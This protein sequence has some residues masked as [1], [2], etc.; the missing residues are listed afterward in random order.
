MLHVVLFSQNNPSSDSSDGFIAVV[1]RATTV[2]MSREYKAE[3]L[4]VSS[5]P[6]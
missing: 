4:G 2:E 1:K 3:K 5:F 6:F